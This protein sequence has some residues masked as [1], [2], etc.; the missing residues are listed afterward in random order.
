MVTRRTCDVAKL[1][2]APR[3]P[4]H[5]DTEDILTIGQVFSMDLGFI[6]GPANLAAVLD[7]TEEAQPKVIE[8]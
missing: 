2:K 8:S 3:G 5:K 4:P 7:R 1:R 6:R